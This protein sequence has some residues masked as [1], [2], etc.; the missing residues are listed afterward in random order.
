MIAVDTRFSAFE[1][2]ALKYWLDKDSS[3]ISVNDL[4]DDVLPLLNDINDKTQTSLDK[5]INESMT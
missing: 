4:P 1:D 2:I 3:S 5:Q